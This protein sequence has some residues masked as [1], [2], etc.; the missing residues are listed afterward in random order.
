MRKVE[1]VIG[2]WFTRIETRLTVYGPAQ[3]AADEVIGASVPVVENYLTS[4]CLL[5]TKE[6]ILPSKALLRPVG[7]FIGK[8]R[9][10]VAGGTK[11]E[12]YDRIQRWRKSSWKNYKS[13]WEAVRKTCRRSDCAQIDEQIR[14][15]DR[16]LAQM[17][18]FREFPTARQILDSGFS[19]E[20]AVRLGIYTQYLGATHIDILTLAQT[21]AQEGGCTEYVGDL[22]GGDSGLERDLL[23]LACLYA[24]TISKYYGW[25]YADILSEYKSLTNSE[26]GKPTEQ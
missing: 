4:A 24:G 15:A 22:V 7:E 8:L 21:V 23:S 9:W 10:C 3:T 25:D 6:G 2:E 16:K 20:T 17:T 1:Q 13:Y 19:E 18:S 12:I 14:E 26:D 11:E 5:A